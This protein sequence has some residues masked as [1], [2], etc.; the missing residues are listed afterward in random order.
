MDGLRHISGF[1][2]MFRKGKEIPRF[3]KLT[4]SSKVVH[5]GADELAH[6]IITNNHLH[7]CIQSLEPHDQ[8]LIHML[9]YEDLT[10]REISKILNRTPSA[11][12]LRAHKALRHLTKK[13]MVG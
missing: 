6:K 9:F 1:N 7:K 12:C 3:T 5:V 2:S 11:I 10:F 4:E 8:E 13:L